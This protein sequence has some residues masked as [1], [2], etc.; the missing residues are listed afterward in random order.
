MQPNDYLN[1]IA[2][3]PPKKPMQNKMV[4][5]GSIGA[6]LIVLVIILSVVATSI[7]NSRR[8]P[9]ER[10]S[11]RIDTTQ[12]IADEAQATLRSSQL[13]SLNS[14]LRLFF[15]NT[16]RDIGTPLAAIG[17]TP[18]SINQLVASEEATRAEAISQRLEDARLNAIF[19]RTYARE[20]SFQLTTILT[21][22]QEVYAGTSNQ[23]VR[24]FTDA[25]YE[26]LE[27]LQAGFENFNE[28]G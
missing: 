7:S 22:L 17:V 20:M 23:S 6:G 10:L 19:D 12:T 16:K 21:L 28:A 8:A 3:Q 5:F 27:P 2:P 18:Q 24:D 4:L 1:Q 13:R 9:A 26:N 25:T 11:V 14:D 15:T